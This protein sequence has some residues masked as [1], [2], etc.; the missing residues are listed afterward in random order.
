MHTTARDPTKERRKS[1]KIIS[2]VPKRPR[3]AF[4]LSLSL[5]FKR[6]FLI[7]GR[8]DAT[9]RILTAYMLVCREFDTS[10]YAVQ[11]RNI[12]TGFALNSDNVSRAFDLFSSLSLSLAVSSSLSPSFVLGP[13]SSSSLPLASYLSFCSFLSL[14]FSFP[15]SSFLTLSRGTVV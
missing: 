3:V 11:K 14:P 13:R 1:A 7:L 15:F 12:V 6:P 2:D 5:S 10:R 4:S 8:T 9:A